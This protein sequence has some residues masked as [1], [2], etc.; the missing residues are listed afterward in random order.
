MSRNGRS[1]PQ[2]VLDEAQANGWQVVKTNGNHWKWTNDK[3]TRPVFSPSTAG[4]RRAW[5]N[6]LAQLRRAL[7]GDPT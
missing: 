5:S 4:D 6:T 2:D 3:A 7:R 1:I